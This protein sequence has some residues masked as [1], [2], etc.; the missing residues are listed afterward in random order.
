MILCDPL[1]SYTITC[2]RI[3]SY[4]TIHAP[5][6]STLTFRAASGAAGELN[7]PC[8]N[9]ELN[10]VLDEAVLLQIR[11]QFA[12]LASH[13]FDSSLSHP[14]PV[15]DFLNWIFLLMGIFVFPAHVR[16]GHPFPHRLCC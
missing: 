10:T 11:T 5:L 2:N 13:Y 4:M 14:L 3:W 6:A 9:F 1:S 7:P 16:D 12:V 8:M 15:L